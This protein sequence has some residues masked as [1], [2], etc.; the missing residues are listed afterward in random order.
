M[1]SL[2]Y[3]CYRSISY[4]FHRIVVGIDP[5]IEMARCYKK[6]FHRLP[7]FN[8][9]QSLIEK[10]YWLQLNTDTSLWSF[11]ADKY[12]VRTYLKE[13]GMGGYLNDLYGVWDNVHDIDFD[14]LP[15]EFVLKTTNGCAQSIVVNKK[16]VCPEW[17]EMVVKQLNSWLR[18]PF[19][20]SGGELHYLNIQPRIIAER[21]L[22]PAK[23]E[24]SLIDYK[25]WCFSGEPFCVFVTYGRSKS[26]FNFALFDLD[27]NLMSQYVQSFGHAKYEPDCKVNRPICFEEMI[28]VAKNLSKGFPEVRIDFY[29]INNRPVFGEMTFSTG[30]GYFTDDFYR[31]LGDKV[32]LPIDIN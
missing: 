12:M 21:M 5:R 24:D 15:E 20:V 26:G 23:N 3:H 30:F 31:I 17:E 4:Y 7:S 18:H 8:N 19:G 13:R 29:Q 32:V 2:L 27:W 9:P 6:V 11:C 25:I 10:I 28:T 14:G 22:H 16:E 1:K